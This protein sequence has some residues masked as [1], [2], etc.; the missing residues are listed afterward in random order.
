MRLSRL[1]L[2]PTAGL[3][4]VLLAGCFGP[5]PVGVP[6][7]VP[8]GTDELEEQI[9]QETGGEVDLDGDAEVP[10]DWPAELPLPPGRPISA[11]VV[12]GSHNLTYRIA[13][14]AI[15]E[16]IVAELVA[17]GF[18]DL[19]GMDTDEFVAH[20]LERDGWNVTIGWVI[21]DEEILLTYTSGPRP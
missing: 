20:T 9:E 17:A 8:G 14:P 11:I 15:G 18:T 19:G 5:A 1:A 16:G 6:G 13:D 7:G 12:D 2:V 10:A 3:G 21:S 4:L